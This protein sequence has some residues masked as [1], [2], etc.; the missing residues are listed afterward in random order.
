MAKNIFKVTTR[1]ILL[2]ILLIFV[3]GIGIIAY[4][5][6]DLFRAALFPYKRAVL[7][8]QNTSPALSTT[9]ISTTDPDRDG[10]PTSVLTD[11]NCKNNCVYQP[12]CKDGETINCSDNCPTISNRNQRDANNNHFGDVCEPVCGDG[13]KEDYYEACDDGN[14]MNG[15]GCSSVCEKESGWTCLGATSPTVCQKCGNGI[16][17]GTE[18]C[19]T[20]GESA[21]CRADCKRK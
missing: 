20:G 4:T 7:I 17:E 8:Q 21:T 16:R 2:V 3:L 6:P 14:L 5:K 12:K 19:D 10:I 1:N 11:P 15:D 13:K 18:V 9:K